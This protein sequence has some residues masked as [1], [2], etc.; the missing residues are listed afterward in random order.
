MRKAIKI[1]VY[2]SFYYDNDKEDCQSYF[3]ILKEEDWNLIEK[4]AK[5]KS[6]YE[7]TFREDSYNE[8]YKFDTFNLLIN[9]FVFLKFNKDIEK[10]KSKFYICDYSFKISHLWATKQDNEKFY[11]EGDLW[12]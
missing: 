5:L 1:K 3:L 4:N 8:V 12:G 9:G 11:S 6:N 10:C 2:S 7:I